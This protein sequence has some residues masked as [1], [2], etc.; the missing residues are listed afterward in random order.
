VY[1]NQTLHEHRP[2]WIEIRLLSPP[3]LAKKILQ[4]RNASDMHTSTFLQPSSK[5]MHHIRPLRLRLLIRHEQRRRRQ[6]S[7]IMMRLRLRL[8]YRPTAKRGR[9]QQRSRDQS[10]CWVGASRHAFHGFS[11]HRRD[12]SFY[13]FADAV[14]VC[15]C[16]FCE[17]GGR[18]LQFGEGGVDL[19][20]ADLVHGDL[21][22][23]FERFGVAGCWED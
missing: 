22:A 12:S 2:S 21:E 1:K 19:V 5:P 7:Q 14:P 23:E 20:C 10:R 15:F 16:F 9:I 18:D 6:R 8:I 13:C 4:I 3:L 17:R 11:P